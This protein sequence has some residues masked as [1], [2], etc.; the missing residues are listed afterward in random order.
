MLCSSEE[1]VGGEGKMLGQV[2]NC[3]RVWGE[4]S[5]IRGGVVA[6]CTDRETLKLF[7]CVVLEERL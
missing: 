3:F 7:A 5:V 2:H 4:L 6:H 1:R